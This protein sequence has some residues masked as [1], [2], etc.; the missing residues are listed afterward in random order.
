MEPRE[1][2]DLDLNIA[3][4]ARPGRR[5]KPLAPRIVRPLRASDL[6]LLAS[7]AGTEPIRLKKLSERHHGLARLIA[8]GTPEREAAAIMRY[9]LSRVSVLKSDP[10]FKELVEFYR[11]RVDEAFDETALHMAGLTLEAIMEL[12]ERLEVE[13][14]SFSIKDLREVA[15]SMADRTGHGPSSKQEVEV[16]VNLG[17]RIEAARRRALE[18]RLAAARDITPE[19]RDEA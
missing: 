11:N 1:T 13:P 7:D 15:T 10:A 16:N 2:F 5:K 18:A 19:A 17:E 9:D 8:A 12:R 4:L 3:G 6:A 14:E